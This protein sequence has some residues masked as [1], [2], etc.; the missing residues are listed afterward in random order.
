MRLHVTILSTALIT[1][2]LALGSACDG[3][4]QPAETKTETKAETK[5]EPP[6]PKEK[7]EEE[8]QEEGRKKNAERLKELDE[9]M[10]KETARWT[11]EVKAKVKALS[12]KN[13]KKTKDAL[14]AILASPHR[15]PENV[16]RDGQRHPAETLEFLGVTP[17]MTVVEIGPGAGWYTEILAPLLVKK[18]KLIITDFDPD[19]PDHEWTSFAGKRMQAFLGRSPELFGKVEREVQKSYKEF[20]LGEDASV[21]FVFFVR[22]MHGWHNGGSLEQNLKEVHRALKPG[23]TLAIVQHR[24]AEGANADESSKKGYL[25]EAW[26]IEQVEKAGFELV[27]KSEVN[28]NPK[29]TKDYSEGVWTLPPTLTLKDTDRDKYVAIGESDRMTLKFR[30][31]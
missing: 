9:E 28:A 5:A 6:A 16:E 10:Q 12:E 17:E 4:K 3:G 19:G 22:G 30:K 8:K 13:W 24:A 27:E 11:D 7:T 31:K 26:V 2:S 25:P 15:V 21:D 23:G 20:S 18:G 1:S 14:K 29:D